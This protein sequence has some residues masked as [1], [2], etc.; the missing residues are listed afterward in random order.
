VIDDIAGQL[1]FAGTARDVAQV[2]PRCAQPDPVAA[3]FLHRIDRQPGP[4]S[5][6][7]HDQPGH[8]R[9]A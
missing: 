2:Q 3:E 8:R 6:H 5:P 4:A 7:S 1:D 9:Y